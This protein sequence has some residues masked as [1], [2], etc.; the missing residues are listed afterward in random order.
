MYADGMRRNLNRFYLLVHQLEE[1][2]P[3]IH[4]LAP[5]VE[6]LETYEAKFLDIARRLRVSA[7]FVHMSSS[8]G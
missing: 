2:P 4:R 1:R 8:L 7:L 3:R 5:L 6:K